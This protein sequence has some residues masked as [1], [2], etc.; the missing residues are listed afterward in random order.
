IERPLAGPWPNDSSSVFSLQSSDQDQDQERER[1]REGGGERRLTP[2]PPP[3]SLVEAW[4]SGTTAPIPKCRELT[5]KRR[6]HAVARLRDAPIDIWRDVIAR[7]EASA[8]CRGQNDRGWVAT[9]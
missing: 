8:F 4:N 3:Q 6:R 9:F 5:P 2:L 7:I 1:A